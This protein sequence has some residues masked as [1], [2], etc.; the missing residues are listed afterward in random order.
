MITANKQMAALSIRGSHTF[1]NLFNLFD[2]E[3][4]LHLNILIDSLRMNLLKCVS[5]Y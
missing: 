5:I 2:L 3:P 4:F 1:V